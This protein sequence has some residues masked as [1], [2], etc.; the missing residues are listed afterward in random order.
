MLPVGMTTMDARERENRNASADNEFTRAFR[1]YEVGFALDGPGLL[2][3]TRELTTENPA[4]RASILAVL[5]ARRFRTALGVARALVDDEHASVRTHALRLLA[6]VVTPD[7]AKALAHLEEARPGEPAGVLDARGAL[8]RALRASAHPSVLSSELALDAERHAIV[9]LLAESAL[10]DQ[11]LVELLREARG[12]SRLIAL[13]ALGT[14]AGDALAR[15]LGGAFAVLDDDGRM[16]LADVARRRG[17]S[18]AAPERAG[19]IDVLARP[20]SMTASVAIHRAL[21]ELDTARLADVVC[22]APRDVSDEAVIALAHALARGDAAKLP[23]ERVLRAAEERPALL[24]ALASTLDAEPL[25]E[26]LLDDESR[27]RWQRV[28]RRANADAVQGTLTSISRIAF[29]RTAAL[30]GRDDGALPTAL[31]RALLAEATEQ[32]RLTLVELARAH[33][34]EEAARALFALADDES[35]EVR[36]AAREAAKR[37]V[38]R[39]VRIDWATDPP[40]LELDHRAPSGELLVEHDVF[41]ID[42]DGTRYALDEHGVPAPIRER[43]RGTCMCCRRARFLLLEN[44]GLK[45]PVTGARHVVD[46]SRAVLA[47]AHPHGACGACA[48]ELALVDKA[49]RVH[50][51]ACGW[52]RDAPAVENPIA[53]AR[54]EENDALQ[55]ELAER[56]VVGVPPAPRPIELGLFRPIQKQIMASHVFITTTD[57]VLGGGIVLSL[58]EQTQACTTL[59]AAS[60]EEITRV[61]EEGVRLYTVNGERSPVRVIA[62]DREL[63]VALVTC[64]LRRAERVNTIH[65]I[66]M[67]PAKSKTVLVPGGVALARWEIA[68]AKLVVVPGD[69]NGREARLKPGRFRHGAGLYTTTGAFLGIVGGDA[70]GASVL[71]LSQ[72]LPWLMLHQS[73]LASL[74]RSSRPPETT[75]VDT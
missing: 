8:A 38:S 18:L 2:A 57:A 70:R 33:E 29:A 45:C 42:R 53:V 12:K 52:S 68:Q 20:V 36:A 47:E 41:V 75:N 32:A 49:G 58:D 7:D 61:D 66:G 34:D 15:A 27:S 13:G 72:L 39:A 51:P 26:A 10:P 62:I 14:L 74:L 46:G 6:S 44:E 30:V 35:A 71:S 11:A 65:E 9:A 31:S 23:A 37:F 59:V 60:P 25:M 22:R 69:L 24:F 19:L 4:E 54:Q 17:S 1:A 40:T 63:G 64:T 43:S 55:T 5:T 28:F 3:L 73:D 56:V 67:W 21:A 16:L 48:T 50:C